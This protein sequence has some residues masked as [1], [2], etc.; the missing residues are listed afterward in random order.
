MPDIRELIE[1]YAL[2]NAVKYGSA[3][4]AG[5]VMGKLLGEHPELRGSAKEISLVIGSV[6]TDVSAM[7]LEEWQNRLRAIAPDLL[8]E[9][10]EKKVPSKGLPEL[11]GVA[12][13]VVMRFA[14]NPN[15]PPTIGSARGIIINSEYVK[16][17]GGRFLLRFDDTDP[18]NKRPILEAYQWYIEDCEWLGASPDE[19][20]VASDRLPLYYEVAEE[21]IRRSAAYV[22]RCEQATFKRYKDAMETCPHRDQESAENLDLWRGMLDG[23]LDEGE[24]VLRI[25]TDILNKDPALRDWAAFRIVTTS[26]PR[27]GDRY[28]VWPLLD[29]ESAVEDHLLEITHILRGKDLIDSERRQRYL[30]SHMGWEYPT[31]VHWGRVKIHQFGSFS[32]STIRRAIEAG[33]YSGWDDPRLPTVRAMKRRGIQPQALRKFMIDMGVSETDISISMDNIYAENRKV[34]DTSANRRFFVKDPVPLN[35]S[36]DVPE[37][38]HPPLH[39]TSDRGFR[40]IPAGRNVLISRADLEEMAVGQKIRLKDFCNL[41]FIEIDPP[42]ALSIGTDPATAKEMNLRIIHW[43]PADGKS[44]VVLRPDGTDRVIGEA[45][46]A[47]EIG[48]V[49]Q[50]ERYGFVRIESMGDEI[51]ACYAHR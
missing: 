13:G 4:K 46:I 41:E 19:V 24:A 27:A 31:T 11:K 23:T 43:A 20:I 8:E 21:L 39:P 14:P 22:C 25:K 42:E 32:T 36:G 28:R 47:D 5:A 18:V 6:L 10:S 29:F 44:V 17:Y 2:Q 3:P 45:G 37:I 1:K 35:I 50:F 15:G 33:E 38:V 9:L 30:Y 16:K 12:G 40:D 49:V 26:H 7:S 34:V 51:L 48:R